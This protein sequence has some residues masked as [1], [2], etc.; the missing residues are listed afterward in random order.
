MS[1]ENNED[2][3]LSL[4]ALISDNIL[5][6][7][8]DINLE[9][10]FSSAF[11]SDEDFSDAFGESQN[12]E[13]EFSDIDLENEFLTNANEHEEDTNETFDE[14]EN[15]L[16]EEEMHDVYKEEKDKNITNQQDNFNN[17]EL[18]D[19]LEKE[20]LELNDENLVD[21]DKIHEDFDEDGNDYKKEKKSLSINIVGIIKKIIIIITVIIILIIGGIFGYNQIEKS[22]SSSNNESFLETN[23]QKEVY[24][25]FK[26][27]ESDIYNTNINL[28]LYLNNRISK[29]VLITNL[30]NTYIEEVEDDTSKVTKDMMYDYKSYHINLLNNLKN[31]TTKEGIDNAVDN[32]I[33]NIKILNK[34]SSEKFK[35]FLDKEGIKYLVDEKGNSFPL[36][37]ADKNYITKKSGKLV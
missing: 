31:A 14:N 5:E 11:N 37:S 10:E 36:K 6:D 21:K 1:K 7:E 9:E 15:F 19:E 24:N 16:N 35:K 29:D 8:N 2:I 13:E 12:L 17:Q 4:D 27:I 26:N 3:G 33:E 20:L 34:E 18:E 25:D 22:N 23:L 32:Y 28:S 30:E